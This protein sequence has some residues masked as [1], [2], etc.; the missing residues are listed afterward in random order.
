ML[1][2]R[3]FLKASLA[4]GSFAALTACSTRWPSNNAPPLTLVSA[5]DDEAGQHYIGA[6]DAAGQARLQIPVPE[7]CHG[8]C[9][10]PHGDHVVVFARRPGRLMHVLNT[11]RGELERTIEA[12]DGYHYYG[13]GV[14]SQDAR[15][16]YVTMNHYHTSAGLVRVYDAFDGYS[17]VADYDLAGIGPHE[18]RLHPD[19]VTLV[20][21][22]A[23][24]ADQRFDLVIAAVKPQLIDDILA[25]YTD[26]LA[27]GGYVLSIAA[28]Y[29]AGR[30]S[31]LMG[32]AP[33]IGLPGCA[34]SPALNGADW[35]LER[36]ICGQEM[37]SA[38]IAAMAVGGLLKEIPTRPQPR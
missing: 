3:R 32:D 20:T 21:D 4:A 25:D 14:Y 9:A 1:D 18:L 2:R 35:V 19:G 31:Q 38:D 24:I 7:R 11:R 22:R 36:V 23:A 6:V 30:L 27:P 28:G 8:G 29:S 13:H 5:V 34:R 16:L 15:Y 26:H 37:T 33:V 10:Q 17:A 12:G